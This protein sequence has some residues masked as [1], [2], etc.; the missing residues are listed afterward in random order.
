VA[1]ASSLTDGEGQALLQHGFDAYLC[2]PFEMSQ[3]IQTID[4]ATSIV[5]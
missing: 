5:H 2:R 1:V 4:E 3:L